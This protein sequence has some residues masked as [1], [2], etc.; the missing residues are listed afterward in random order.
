MVNM[1]QIS[2]SSDEDVSPR[3]TVPIRSASPPCRAP[4]QAALSAAVSMAAATVTAAS[5]YVGSGRSITNV[6]GMEK[7]DSSN[8]SSGNLRQQLVIATGLR[9]ADGS[10]DAVAVA[11]AAVPNE[12]T[13]PTTRNDAHHSRHVCGKHNNSNN[14]HLDSSDDD[15]NDDDDNLDP[16][17]LVD[18]FDCEEDVQED[19]E[20]VEESREAF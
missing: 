16:A 11:A 9:T 20:E 10:V 4:S 18:E 14:N 5:P 19:E 7:R 6:R 12:P 15:D 17:N 3:P 13:Q 1:H 8:G 2:D